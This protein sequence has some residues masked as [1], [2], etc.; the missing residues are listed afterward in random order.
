MKYKHSPKTSAKLAELQKE[1]NGLYNR[2]AD[3]KTAQAIYMT[4]VPPLQRASARIIAEEEEDDDDDQ[5]D[6]LTVTVH[7][8]IIILPSGIEY[9][10]TMQGYTELAQKETRVRIAQAHDALETIRR[11]QRVITGVNI[12][13]KAQLAGAGQK[14]TTCTGSYYNR[15]KIK[16]EL[17]TE[18]YQIAWKALKKL[19]PDGDWKKSLKELNKDDV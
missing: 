17:A 1:C 4:Y 3:W 9:A 18:R 16:I 15:L 8:I 6:E 10:E 5:T 11:L 19:D 13:K 7:D 2:F 14:V 12:F